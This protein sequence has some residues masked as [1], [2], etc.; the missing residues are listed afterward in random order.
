MKRGKNLYMAF[1]P[2]FLVFLIPSIASAKQ[3]DANLI[4]TDGICKKIIDG[5][6]LEMKVQG[7]EIKVSF[8]GAISPVDVL[9]KFKT[10]YLSKTSWRYL[11]ELICGET[12]KLE[13]SKDVDKNGVY[14]AYVKT[15]SGTDINAELIKRGF[16]EYNSKDDYRMK[17]SFK[18][19]Q[20]HAEK[21]I[22]GMWGLKNMG[23]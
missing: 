6:T 9:P 4:K 22:V 18:K 3:I 1:L 17:D 16:A 12:L 8:I 5:W 14:R 11:N 15:L 13:I 2:L 21:T 23:I 20:D 10:R 19:L 7:R